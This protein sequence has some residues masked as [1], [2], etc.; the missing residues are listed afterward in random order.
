LYYDQRQVQFTVHKATIVNNGK[1]CICLN[2]TNLSPSREIEVTHI[3][4]I[5]KPEIYIEQSGRI[6]PKRLKPYESWET[7]MEVD[8]LPADIV[9]RP[10]R[11]AKICLSNNQEI[12]SRR[13]FKVQGRGVVPGGPI[14]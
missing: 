10:Y 13:K 12:R 4:F 6:L 7:W 14:N 8:S 5:H 2:V 11:K 1:E 9:K 3:W